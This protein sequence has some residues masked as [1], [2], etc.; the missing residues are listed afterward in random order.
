MNVLCAC[1]ESQAVTIAMRNR[2]INAYSCDILQ[3]SGG[4][5]EWHIKGDALKIINPT[6]DGEAWLICFTTMDGQIHVI[7]KWDMIIAFP[8]CTYLTVA[9]NRWFNIERYGWKAIQRIKNRHAAVHFFMAFVNA[10]CNRIAI[11]NPVGVMS[12]IYR[13]PD[14]IIHPFHFGDP[15]RKATCLWLKGLPPLRQTDVVKPEI[16]YYKNGKGTDSP[17]HMDTL[18]LPPKERAKARSKTYQG[19]AEAMADQWTNPIYGIIDIIE[20]DRLAYS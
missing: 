12:T 17:W 19:I 20:N 9:G 8:P 3:C 13:K 2:G 14:Q 18:S 11:E 6:Y 7:E 16:I 10:D 4:H 5:P 15:Q 1:E